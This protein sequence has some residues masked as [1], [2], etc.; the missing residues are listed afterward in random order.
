MVE[1][2]QKQP[3]HRGL[4]AQRATER[5]RKKTQAGARESGRGVADAVENLQLAHGEEAGRKS[6]QHEGKHEK[7]SANRILNGPLEI[8]DA[9]AVQ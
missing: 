1:E 8:L 7:R 9:R 6:Q 4:V 5:V 3:Q 2:T